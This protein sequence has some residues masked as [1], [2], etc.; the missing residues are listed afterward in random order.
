M[1]LAAETS[2]DVILFNIDSKSESTGKQNKDAI[3]NVFLKVFNQMQGFCGSIPHVADLER[4][5]SEEGRYEEFKAAF[6]EEYGEPWEASRQDFDFIQ[7]SVVD[8]LVSMEFMS[9]VAARNWCEKAVEPYTISI[10]DFAK[11]VK[12][13]IDRKGNN[14]HVVFLVDEIGQYIGDDSKLMLNLQTVTE[15]L[16]KEC[17][18]KAWVIVTSQ[19]DIDSITKVKGNDF[20]KIQGRFDTRLSL[21]SANV[22]AVIKKRI[23]ERRMQRRSP[24]GCF[25]S[26]RQPSSRTSSYSTT[27]QR[28]TV[29]KRNRFCRGL[30]LCAVSVQ[31]ALQCLDLH[32]YPR[33]VRQA[34][35]WR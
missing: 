16:G 26:R 25:M 9:E 19:Q 23:L 28:K 14:H 5:L 11:R 24:S 27:R 35:V 22:D 21:S 7:D 1:K 3:V 12:S 4:R 15:E 20:S 30:S 32:S 6:E 8:A 34:P 18:G 10:E 33:C 29:C 17:M 2:T 13:Y 31:P